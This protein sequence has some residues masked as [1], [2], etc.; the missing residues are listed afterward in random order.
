MRTL[1]FSLLSFAAVGLLCAATGCGE[2]TLPSD[3]EAAVRKAVADYFASKKDSRREVRIKKIIPTSEGADVRVG[4]K[5]PDFHSVET[6]RRLVAR[7]TDRVWKVEEA[8]GSR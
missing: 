2:A 5:F 8:K 7:R 6:E 4:V 3:Q 1:R